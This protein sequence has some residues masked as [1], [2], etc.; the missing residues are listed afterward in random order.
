MRLGKPTIALLVALAVPVPVAWAAAVGD[1]DRPQSLR[2]GGLVIAW[3]FTQQTAIVAPGAEITVGVR[4]TP[5]APTG[6]VARVT[7]VRADQPARGPAE[8]IA[9]VRLRHGRVSVRLPDASARYELRV[10]V[11]RWSHRTAIDAWIGC[12]GAAVRQR[13]ALVTLRLDRGRARPGETVVATLANRGR[14][15]FTTGYGL[16]WERRGADGGWTQAT[17]V[18]GVP[19]PAIALFLRPGQDLVEQLSVWDAM[20]PGD[21][22]LVKRLTTG[23]PRPSGVTIASGVLT[24]VGP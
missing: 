6:R 20:P 5:R 24:V 1:G 13:Q 23:H 16:G 3:P 11:G 10:A 18:P 9:R 17:D 15:C 4:A 22:R 19:V 14:S 7:L 2:A 8:A 21:Y 12:Q